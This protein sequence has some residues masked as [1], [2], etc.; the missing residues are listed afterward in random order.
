MIPTLSL[1]P[2][3]SDWEAFS[4]CWAVS[5]RVGVWLPLGLTLKFFLETVNTVDI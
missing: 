2:A 4:I 1:K 5:S 3:W